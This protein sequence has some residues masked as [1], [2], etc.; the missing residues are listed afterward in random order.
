M[1]SRKKKTPWVISVA[2]GKGGVGKTLTTVNMASAAQRSGLKTLV[3]DGDLGLANVDIVLGLRGRYNIGDVLD[4]RTNLKDILLEGPLGFHIIPSGSGFNRLTEMKLVQRVQLLDKVEEIACDY[5]LLIIDTGAGISDNVLHLNSIADA[6][7]VVTTPEPHALAD[8]YAFIKVMCEHHGKRNFNLVV[9]QVMSDAQ[10]HKVFQRFAD[11]SKRFLDLDLLL[12]GIVPK[13]ALIERSVMLQRA[14]DESITHTRSG[15]AW[16]EMTR[17]VVE[18]L[19][20][21]PS[22]EEPRGLGDLMF[23]MNNLRSVSTL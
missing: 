12:G 7:L 3:L 15:Q 17:K 2:S 16:I 21:S 4:A 19:R 23:P 6:I 14:A 8:A 10:G 9:N 20:S 13:D 5:D 22:N 18:R 11:T 1:E